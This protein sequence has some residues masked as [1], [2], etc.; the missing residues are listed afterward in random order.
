MAVVDELREDGDGSMGLEA[1]H[2]DGTMDVLTRNRELDWLK[3]STVSTEKNCRILTNVRCLS[4]GV[5]VPALDAVIFLSPRDSIVEVVQSVG[6]VMRKAPG[7]KYGYVILPIGIPGDKDPEKALDDNKKY[8]VVWQVLNALRAHDERLE[9]EFA[10]IDLNK[11]KDDKINV[12][13]VKA[14]TPPKK[15]RITGDGVQGAFELTEENLDHW[16]DAIYAKVVEK[17]GDRRYWESWAK[18]VAEI[19]QNHRNRIEHL[20]KHPKP[21]TKEAF[22]DFLTGLR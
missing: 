4:E 21:G 13:G 17:C 5:D 8:K 18:D 20:L 1:H 2:V 19:A 10:T 9:R 12:I 22:D 3:K 14:V 15:D 16:R 7:K 11:K 6:R